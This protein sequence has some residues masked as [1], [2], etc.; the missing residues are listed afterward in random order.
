MP[1][2][3]A[4]SSPRS[5]TRESLLGNGAATRHT[6]PT[7]V[8]RRKGRSNSNSPTSPACPDLQ[9]AHVLALEQPAADHWRV[10]THARDELQR[11]LR[12][13]MT[14]RVRAGVDDGVPAIPLL[15]NHVPGSGA[16]S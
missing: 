3:S 2:C 8:K 16:S 11:D 9:H 15:P 6:R 12:E 13:A 14:A 1:C 4:S 10:M 5:V 7:A